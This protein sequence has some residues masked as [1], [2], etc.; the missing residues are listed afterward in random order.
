[1]FS[2]SNS[3]QHIQ[4]KQQH[5]YCF[6]FQWGEHVWQH[7]WSRFLLINLPV[8]GMFQW[9]L[10]LRSPVPSVSETE[11]RTHTVTPDMMSNIPSR[12][13][14]LQR[15]REWKT[16]ITIERVSDVNKATYS[17][18]QTLLQAVY[19]LV[20]WTEMWG[21]SPWAQPEI[22]LQNKHNLKIQNSRLLANTIFHG[23]TVVMLGMMRST[24]KIFHMVVM[25]LNSVIGNQYHLSNKHPKLYVKLLSFSS[26]IQNISHETLEC[27]A[28]WVLFICGPC[29]AS[30]RYES[31][32]INS[33]MI[34]YLSTRT[35]NT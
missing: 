6:V 25:H 35:I 22:D 20:M 16:C 24:I 10:V 17:F 15:D 14:T 34:L 28:L 18:L 33:S 8:R 19:P 32:C 29:N 11:L 5:R 21:N 2:P 13:P 1:M 23:Y 31:Y 26:L 27:I 30:S 9:S 12:A 7:G 3:S 4:K